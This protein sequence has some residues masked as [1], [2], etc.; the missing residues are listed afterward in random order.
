MT[1]KGRTMLVLFAL[2]VVAFAS[3]NPHITVNNPFTSVNVKYSASATAL[4]QAA[5]PPRGTTPLQA[6]LLAD[7][8]HKHPS[9]LEESLRKIWNSTQRPEWA[10]T[11]RVRLLGDNLTNTTSKIRCDKHKGRKGSQ[12]LEDFYAFNTFFFGKGGGVFLETGALNGK[13]YSNTLNFEDELGWKGLLIEAS[14]HSYKE[15]VVN[16]PNQINVHAALCNEART[17]HWADS[18]DTKG[19]KF[20][21]AAV[22]GIVEFMAPQFKKRFWGSGVGAPNNVT[23]AVTFGQPLLCVPLAAILDMYGFSKIN[24]FSL[25]VEGGE[26]EVLQSIDF[27]K[28]SFDVVNIEAD[29]KNRQKDEDVRKLMESKG[30]RLYKHERSGNND[31]FV[32]K[33]FRP[34]A[35]P[36]CPDSAE[37]SYRCLMEKAC[38]ESL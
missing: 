13:L 30:F 18:R 24:W 9:Q 34:S 16:R 28:V 33:G 14:P 23:G 1:V 35:N 6:P 32:R 20:V 7:A 22:N 5:P 12:S 26:F 21:N 36:L 17:V 37:T 25:D 10:N 11:G 19:G 27:S 31:W 4:P 38:K 3:Y 29:G 2:S 8:A 15:L